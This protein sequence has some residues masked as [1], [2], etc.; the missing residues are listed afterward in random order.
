[1][2]RWGTGETDEAVRGGGKLAEGEKDT[3]KD[4]RLSGGS[5]ERA[6]RKGLKGS[7]ERGL[8]G[9]RAEREESEEI[10]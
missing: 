3:E 10:N 5:S 9:K 7:K 1:M 8:N 6:G 4:G 2:G